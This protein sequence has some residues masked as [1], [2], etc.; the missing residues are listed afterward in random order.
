MNIKFADQR[1]ELSHE[2][3]F[4]G[5]LGLIDPFTNT[6]MRS[7]ESG[8]PHTNSQNSGQ[9]LPDV[10][11]TSGMQIMRAP[12]IERRKS[13][14]ESRVNKKN[15]GTHGSQTQGNSSLRGPS[16]DLDQFIIQTP[17]DPIFFQ[18]QSEEG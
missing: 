2:K 17:K 4:E 1:P 18:Q 10:I 6:A 7:F 8:Y 3:R 5:S 13:S 12:I 9:L 15:R 14:V 11:Q 16:A